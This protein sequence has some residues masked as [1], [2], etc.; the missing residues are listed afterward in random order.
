[1]E[2][3]V[4]WVCV[5][6]CVCAFLRTLMLVKMSHPLASF[7]IMDCCMAACWHIICVVGRQGA[8]AVFRGDLLPTMCWRC[9]AWYASIAATAAIIIVVVIFVVGFIV[10]V[11]II[12]RHGNFLSQWLQPQQQQVAGTASVSVRSGATSTFAPARNYWP[13]HEWQIYTCKCVAWK[14]QQ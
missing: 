11:Y 5:C 6:V 13:P 8:L 1:M 3:S 7:P 12:Q 4:I 10:A 14:L 2:A 9:V